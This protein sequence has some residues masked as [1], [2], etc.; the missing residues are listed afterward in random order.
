MS[1]VS[2]LQYVVP[3]ECFNAGKHNGGFRLGRAL[4]WCSALLLPTTALAAAWTLTPELNLRSGYDD[5]LSLTPEGTINGVAREANGGVKT[6]ASVAMEVATLTAISELRARGRADFISY[7][8]EETVLR[9][10]EE[11]EK[12]DSEDN[13]YIDVV[14]RYKLTSIND[15]G[16]SFSLERKYTGTGDRDFFGRDAANAVAGDQSDELNIDTDIGVSREQVRRERILFEPYWSVGLTQNTRL[17]LEYRYDD[18]V[19][20]AGAALARLRDFTRH[21]ASVRLE[22][23]LSE[24]SRAF[25]S[26]DGGAYETD[27]LTVVDEVDG[28]NVVRE[29]NSRNVDEIAARF[30]YRYNFSPISVL[31]FNL[32]VRQLSFD[33]VDLDNAESDSDEDVGAIVRVFGEY[34]GELTRYTANIGRTI[35]PSGSGGLVESDT[36]QFD[37]SRSLSPRFELRFESEYIGNTSVGDADDGRGDRDYVRISPMLRWNWTPEWSVDLAYEYEWEERNIN[38]D[39]ES[40]KT[41]DADSNGVFLSIVYRKDNEI[42]QRN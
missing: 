31:G 29:L 6:N 40:G 18:A 42:G 37:F 3:S 19:Y 1:R 36:L 35:T 30:G 11:Q 33:Q 38:T 25:F 16:A 23:S 26:I 20:G 10:T 28:V 24:T 27:K 15:I 41:F 17:R 21:R 13:Q 5:N 12:L 9:G 32:G 7:A 34:R 2:E 14:G 8:Q 22:H 4:L 39:I